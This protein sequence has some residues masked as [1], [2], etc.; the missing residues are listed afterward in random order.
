MDTSIMQCPG[1]GSPRVYLDHQK[2]RL[3]CLQCGS[4][5]SYSR[6]T[7][8]TAAAGIVKYRWDNASAYFKSGK[9]E[10]AYKFAR[11][12]LDLAMDYIP[13]KY[14]IAFY[15]EYII[16]KAG[17]LK[18]FFRAYENVPLEYDEVVWLE[19][20]FTAFPYKLIELE[21]EVIKMI[22]LNLQ[23]EDEKQELCGFIDSVCPFWIMK[24]PSQDFLDKQL[25]G[26]YQEL[27]ERCSI[28]K[29]CFALLSA[30]TRNPDSPYY[31]G[32]FELKIKN[33]YF[34]DYFCKPIGDIITGMADREL[35]N[36][37]LE[38]YERSIK[39]YRNNTGV[40]DIISLK[41]TE[42]TE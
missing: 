5:I 4:E 23:A 35:R 13:A 3:I 29:T 38:Q 36:R 14:I 33:Q 19:Q 26:M 30:I 28:P 34:Y 10:L 20:L 6:A 24:R 21:V 27:A 8:G 7:A 18:Q 17:A 16:K 41:G 12:T 37:F 22:A 32:E 2:R 42:G 11:E 31:R 15:E 9:F 39:E 25:A 1:C 40:K